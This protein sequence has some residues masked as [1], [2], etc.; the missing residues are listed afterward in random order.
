MFTFTFEDHL[1]L[2]SSSNNDPSH[3]PHYM[4]LTCNKFA[5]ALLEFLIQ[6]TNQYSCVPQHTYPYTVIAFSSTWDLFLTRADLS[7]NIC[8]TSSYAIQP[9]TTVSHR[10]PF[11]EDVPWIMPGWD[12]NL[13]HHEDRWSFG[14]S[15]H[16]ET[17]SW[18]NLLNITFKNHQWAKQKT[19]RPCRVCMC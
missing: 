7:D 6:E 9:D 13:L 3:P 11:T 4:F 16:S 5:Y 1:V 14:L 19:R 15:E 18:S 2:K 10:T 12:I 17:C 8:G